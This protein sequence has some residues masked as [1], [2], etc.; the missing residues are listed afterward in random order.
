MLLLCPSFRDRRWKCQ[1]DPGNDL[2]HNPPLRHPRHFCGRYCVCECVCVCVCVCFL[3]IHFI[4]KNS[5]S[6]SSF[7]I[8]NTFFIDSVSAFRPLS[9]ISPSLKKLHNAT[10]RLELMHFHLN[11]NVSDSLFNY[12]GGNVYVMLLSVVNVYNALTM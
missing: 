5:C 12:G 3:F 4:E 2:D 10:H 6:L 7:A 9:H 8:E 11:M 1:D